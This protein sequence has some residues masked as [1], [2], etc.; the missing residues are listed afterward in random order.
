MDNKIR[1]YAEDPANNFL[2][3]IGR[4][5]TYSPP[6]GPGVRVDDGFLK[7]EWIYRFTMIL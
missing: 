2:P 5:T 7:K 6:K 1:V 4:L 3:D